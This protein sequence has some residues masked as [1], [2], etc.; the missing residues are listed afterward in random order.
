MRAARLVAARVAART[1]TSSRRLAA[2]KLKTTTRAR[3]AAIAER[4]SMTTGERSNAS[5]LAAVR[6]AMAKR[7]VRAVVVPSQDPHFRR[8]G[9]AKANE[10]NE[11]RRRARR[12][13]LTNGRGRVFLWGTQ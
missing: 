3:D 8:V 4:A 12:E 9:E 1:P 2:R 7:G 11:E 13:R 5:K 10:R 6:E